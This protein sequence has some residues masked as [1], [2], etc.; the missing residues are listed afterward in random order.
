M[1][2]VFIVNNGLLHMKDSINNKKTEQIR[3]ILQNSASAHKEKTTRFF[4]TGKGH[5]AEDDKFMGVTVPVLRE[6]AKRFTCITLEEIQELL[7]S[8]INEERLLALIILV[9]QYEKAPNDVKKDIYE[10]YLNNL[11]NVNNWN[12]VDASA[13]LIMGAHLID[14]HKDILLKL[15]KSEIM[16]ERRIAIVSTWYFIR[17]NDLHWTF[18]IAEM[19]LNDK[20]DLIHKA[21]GWMLRE[22]GKRD[23]NQLIY[24]LNQYTPLMPR[25]MLRYS[26]EKFPKHQRDF[27]LMGRNS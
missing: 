21:V 16:W 24:F 12:L 27:Y 7:K 5:Y 23:Q 26:I 4:K 1:V 25:T 3:L 11:R 2:G 17:K 14:K 8:K 18:K 22:A 19:L 10:F 15:A 9:R 6:T 20:H 13:H